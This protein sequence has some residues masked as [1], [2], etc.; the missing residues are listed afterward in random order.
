MTPVAYTS[1][2]G[3]E[4]L[5]LYFEQTWASRLVLDN[6]SDGRALQTTA[7]HLAHVGWGAP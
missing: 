1:V 5:L 2:F 7:H 6:R 4:L 3:L